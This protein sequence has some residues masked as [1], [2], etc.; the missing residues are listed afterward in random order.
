MSDRILHNLEDYFM[1]WPLDLRIFREVTRIN[2][3]VEKSHIELNYDEKSH[4]IPKM[5]LYPVQMNA[6]PKL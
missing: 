4:R 3:F 1:L 2:K 5:P 6:D